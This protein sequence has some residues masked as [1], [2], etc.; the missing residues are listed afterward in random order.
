[1]K[2]ASALILCAATA[3]AQEAIETGKA[4]SD[5]DF[6]RIVSCAAPPNGACQK[7]T[8]RWSA[9]DAQDVSIGIVATDEAYPQNLASLANRALDAA[10]D[11]VN[12][13]GAK[14]RVRLSSISEIPD[15]AIYLLTIRDGEKIRHTGRDPLD[16]TNIQAARAQLWWRSD[17][18]IIDGVI[19]LAMDIPAADITSVMLEEVTQA[20]GLLTDIDNPIYETISIFSETSNQV[21]KLGTQDIMALRRHYP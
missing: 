12:A 15:I 5:N 18:T 2:L 14:L 19:V 11:E 13:S 20:M 7:D 17:F 1:M 9:A 10:I 6:Y 16:G 21:T 3:Q 4:L 8:V